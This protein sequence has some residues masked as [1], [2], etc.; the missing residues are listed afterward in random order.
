MSNQYILLGSG[1]HAK[2]IFDMLIENNIYIDAI[3]T[4]EDELLEV[5]EHTKKITDDELLEYNCS[6]TILINGIGS[7]PSKA[8]HKDI[9]HRFNILGFKFLTLVSKYAVVSPSVILEEGVVVM[10]GSVIQSGSHIHKNTIVNTNSSIDHDCIVGAHCHVA[11]G[12]ILSGSVVIGD[13]VHIGTAAS[14]INNIKVGD[15]CLIG[16]GSVIYK[17]VMSHSKVISHSRMNIERLK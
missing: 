3:A 15:H 17:D 13:D 1:G 16:A 8:I 10:A 11:P 5:F 9:F 12:A 7:L 6:K 14:L 2:V 4:N